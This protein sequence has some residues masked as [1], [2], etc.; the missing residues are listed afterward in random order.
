MEDILGNILSQIDAG[1]TFKSARLVSRL[2]LRIT[3]KLFPDGHL[4]FAN[5]LET[6]LEKV[7]EYNKN[8]M[9]SMTFPRNLFLRERQIYLDMTEL[10]RNPNITWEFIKRHPE[11]KWN[12]ELFIQGPNMV[13]ELV[14]PFLEFFSEDDCL[15]FSSKKL[16][17]DSLVK[18]GIDNYELEDA[19]VLTLE[20]LQR[21]GEITEYDMANFGDEEVILKYDLTKN[22]DV[23]FNKYL[24]CEFV[25]Q[26]CGFKAR[27][28]AIKKNFVYLCKKGLI[29]FKQLDGESLL[30]ISKGVIETCRFI[31][32]V[33]ALPCD[34]HQF[35]G[36]SCSKCASVE[37][38]QKMIADKTL[39]WE[40]FIFNPNHPVYFPAHLKEVENQ[41]LMNGRVISDARYKLYVDHGSFDVIKQFLKNADY[42]SNMNVPIQYVIDNCLSSNVSRRPDLTWEHVVKD[43][44]AKW[45]VWGYIWSNDFGVST[46]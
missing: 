46:R 19:P 31:F 14:E 34:V 3:H 28:Y 13:D 44:N 35:I 20:T 10:S 21:V 16:S 33:Q 41:C 43:M 1:S 18:I 30:V 5:H 11:L 4:K 29:E 23:Q 32:E 8:I 25:V 27:E 38:L 45:I 40:D 12:M 37:E 42:S 36:Q 24:S 17:W 2:W 22:E 9:D 6:I 7:L 39:N 26:H 15:S